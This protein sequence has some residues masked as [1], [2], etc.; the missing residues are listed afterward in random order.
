MS[1]LAVTALFVGAAV[2]TAAAAY[3]HL[4]MA[5][6][7]ASAR[8]WALAGYWVLRTAVVAAFSFF[9]A[10][11][12][13]PRTHTRSPIAFI[14]T[15]AALGA[16]LL[17]TQPAPDTDTGLVLL[18]DVIALASYVWL[19]VAV[20]YLGRCFGLLPEARGLVTRGPYRLVRHPVYLGE[21]GAVAGFLV[22]A[23]SLWNLGAAA[24]FV[25]AQAVRMRLEER[26]LER[27]FPEY[28]TY[29]AATPRLLPRIQ[30]PPSQAV[31][32]SR[33]TS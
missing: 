21:F 6:T 20:L 9:V 10:V 29:A 8:T 28:G 32:G 4:V 22:G 18:G 26:A 27:E 14:S 31:A 1:R 13:D 17:L 25:A 7:D 19:V 3:D 30:R 5:V 2:V 11:R 15:G 16:M 33:V 12:A 24:M 23:P